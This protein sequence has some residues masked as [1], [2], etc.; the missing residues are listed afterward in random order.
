MDKQSKKIDKLTH[1]LINEAGL[2]NPSA[3]FFSKV[4][5]KIEI[6]K[7]SQPIVFQPL[8]SKKAWLLIISFAIVV[9]TLLTMYP[10]IDEFSLFQ[11]PSLSNLSF[12]FPEMHL[13]K[14][15]IYGIGFLSLFLIQ[16]PFLKKQIDQRF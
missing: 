8:I 7:V 12:K 15:A 5:D 2:E 6:Q 16:I 11:L 14:T 9:I 13:S 3:D 10:I 4:M 1:Q